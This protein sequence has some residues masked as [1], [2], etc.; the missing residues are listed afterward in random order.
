ME[1]LVKTKEVRLLMLN[2]FAKAA[3]YGSLLGGLALV[4]SAADEKKDKAEKAGESTEKGAR[5]AGDAA[6]KAADKAGDAAEKAADATGKGVGAA[7]EH[8][9]RGAAKGAKATAGAVTGAGRAVKDFFTDDQDLDDAR[10]ERRVKSAQQALQA[11]G[12]YSG[13]I[14]GKVND[15]TGSGVRE[16]QRDNNLKV[17]GKVD[18]QTAAK[19]GIE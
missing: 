17:T 7:V 1:I 8:G 9:G 16:F 19:L 12:Y 18:K 5:K 13:P 4:A 14:D 2:T 10:Y 6:D 3:L 15:A 11:K